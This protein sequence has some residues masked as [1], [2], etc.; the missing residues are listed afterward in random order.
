MCA[1]WYWHVPHRYDLHTI[2]SIADRKQL[3]I[4]GVCECV[5]VHY[6]A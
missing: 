6:P 4:A 3:S 2:N 5:C 1:Y